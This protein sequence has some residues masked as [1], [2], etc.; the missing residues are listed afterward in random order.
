[1]KDGM[2]LIQVKGGL[3]VFWGETIQVH[4]IIKSNFCMELEIEGE[5]FEEK[6]WIIFIYASTDLCTMKMQWDVLLE[7]RK[8]LERRWVLGGISMRLKHW[9]T[10]K[11]GTGG[12][13]S[14]SPFRS[15]IRDMKMEQVM[16]KERRWT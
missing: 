4:Q 16:F 2:Q 3:L 5:G 1:M 9:R 12:G 11:V 6:C 8:S 10:N 14:F 7:K 15:F 13:N